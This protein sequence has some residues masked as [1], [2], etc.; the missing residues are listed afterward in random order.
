MNQTQVLRCT[1]GL[2]SSS[3]YGRCVAK[4]APAPV[5]SPC[6]R[7]S[8]CLTGARSLVSAT[9]VATN[10]T[11]AGVAESFYSWCSARGYALASCRMVQS[12]VAASLKGNLG[13]RA[14]A[15]CN[16]LGEC[17][18]SIAADTTCQPAV[19]AVGANGTVVRG[20]LDTCTV[21]G[22]SG[23]SQVTGTASGSGE[24]MFC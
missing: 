5:L 7:C 22:V 21:E 3:T 20:S 6:D 8:A 2:D 9:A 24:G 11:A 10:A 17:A 23:G 16:R 12:A 18:A 4:P 19:A 15:L 13:R 14:G 1:G